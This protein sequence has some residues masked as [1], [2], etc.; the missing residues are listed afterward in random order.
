ML[1]AHG[2]ERTGASFELNLLIVQVGRWLE[3]IQTQLVEENAKPNPR[4]QVIRTFDKR[5]IAL[6]QV[7]DEM[8]ERDLSAAIESLDEAFP[9]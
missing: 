7:M 8:R 6:D 5:S 1:E 4:R 9:S 2:V 3:D